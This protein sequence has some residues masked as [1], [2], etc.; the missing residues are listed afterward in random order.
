MGR[1]VNSKGEVTKEYYS[2]PKA[3]NKCAFANI[4]NG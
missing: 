1:E 2:E 3:P 4:V